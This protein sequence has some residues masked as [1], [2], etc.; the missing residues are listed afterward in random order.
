MNTRS[1]P[2]SIR[3]PGYERG[4]RLACPICGSEIEILN[5]CTCHPSDQSFRCCGQE[6]RPTTGVSVNVNVED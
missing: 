4:Q 5:P 3:S 1:E 2:R 6:M